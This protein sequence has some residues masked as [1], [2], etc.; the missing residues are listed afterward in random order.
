MTSL[1]HHVRGAFFVPE[2]VRNTLGVDRYSVVLQRY[3][4]N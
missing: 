3:F 2:S 4:V 1:G